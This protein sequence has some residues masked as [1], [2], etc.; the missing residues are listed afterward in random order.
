ML[1]GG[2]NNPG[3]DVVEEIEWMAEIGLEFIDLTLE[4]PRAAVW[5]VDI[6]RVRSALEEH[7]LGV[8]GH[9]AYYLPLASAFE[10]LRRAAVDETRRC[11]AAFAEFGVAWVNVHPDRSANI[12]DR[13]LVIG[14][15][16]RS[17]EELLAAARE[18]GIGLMLEN[19]PGHFNTAAQMAELLGPLPELG[20]HL[21][22]G[23]CNLLTETNTTE[24]ILEIY[25][26]RLRHVH[27]HDNKGGNADLHLPLGTGTVDV[28]RCIRALKRAGY[29]GTITLE[30]FTSD[31]HHVAYSRDV[32]RQIWDDDAGLDGR[33]EAPIAPA[34]DRAVS[35][36]AIRPAPAAG[37][38]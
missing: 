26:A 23:H 19:T 34:R 31:K 4:P 29:D 11:L 1:I 3:H 9:T 25:G 36:E 7:K 5:N 2:M 21:D 6:K 35:S 32:L 17:L 12:L 30:V 20:L 13:K 28:P 15:N 33:R 27:L 38:S 10:S 16:L 24:S 8:V 22:I 37:K 18:H 14:R